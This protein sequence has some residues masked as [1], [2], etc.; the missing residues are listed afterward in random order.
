MFESAQPSGD[1]SDPPLEE[2]VLVRAVSPGMRQRSDLGAGRF[3]ATTPAGALFLVPRLSPTRIDVFDIHIIRAFALPNA[4]LSPL[5]EEVRPSGDPLDFGRLH[6][7]P[8]DDP[9]AR[10][11]VDRMWDEGARGDGAGRLYVES[12]VMALTVV[13]LRLADHPVR[14]PHGGLAPWQLRRVT[15]HMGRTSTGTSRWPSSRPWSASRR[16]TSAAPSR[17]APACRRIAGWW[18]AGSSARRR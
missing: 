7:G 8:F 9:H 3:S 1:M 16:T 14:R 17:P 13:L 11:L 2:I 10:M 4:L 15:D 12:A 6:S 18:S 5:L